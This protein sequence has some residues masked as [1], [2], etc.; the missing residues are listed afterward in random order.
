MRN[1]LVMIV[2]TLFICSGAL[3]TD[4]IY[5]ET[6]ATT[7]NEMDSHLSQLEKIELLSRVV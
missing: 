3:G 6:N 4:L 2:I 1:Y 7:I 5:I